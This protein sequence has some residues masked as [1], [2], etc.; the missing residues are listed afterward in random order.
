MFLKISGH[1]EARFQVS[2]PDRLPHDVAPQPVQ[3]LSGH[4]RSGNLGDI[5]GKRMHRPPVLALDL[6]PAG[7]FLA[8]GQFSCSPCAE[9][10]GTEVRHSPLRRSSRL[11]DATTFAASSSPVSLSRPPARPYCV[12]LDA[13]SGCSWRVL[14]CCSCYPASLNDTVVSRTDMNHQPVTRNLSLCYLEVLIGTG[15]RVTRI[16][17]HPGDKYVLLV[18]LCRGLFSN[19]PGFSGK[20]AGRLPFIEIA[21]KATYISGCV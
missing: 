9:K 10:I 17:A 14:R 6:G 21:K 11:A 8:G 20:V 3:K 2:E 12:V 19:R 13:A 7:C 18:H 1:Y 4:L 5:L 16:W 15:D